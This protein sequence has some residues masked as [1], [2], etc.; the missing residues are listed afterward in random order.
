[1][2]DPAWI[3]E[4]AEKHG[5]FDTSGRGNEAERLTKYAAVPSHG[6]GVPVPEKSWI[7]RFAKKKAF[8]GLGAYG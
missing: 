3:V 6:S 5:A 7:Y 1:M 4:M 2:E 8:F